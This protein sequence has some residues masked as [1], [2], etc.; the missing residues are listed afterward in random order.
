MTKSHALI[1]APL[2]LAFRRSFEEAVGDRPEYLTVA[3]LRRLRPGAAVRQLLR[4]R[5]GTCYLPIEDETSSAI[6]PVLQAVALIGAPRSIEVVDPNLVRRPV[7]RMRAARGVL[8]LSAASLAGQL[9]LRRQTRELIRLAAMPRHEVS[10]GSTQRV[11]YFNGNLWFGLKAGG[12]V[13]HVAGVVNGFVGGGLDVDLATA[14]TPP[15]VRPEVNV[16][17]LEPPRAFG[18]PVEANIYRFQPTAV[19]AVLRRKER[20][21]FVYQRMSVGSFAG[22][23]ISRRLGIPLV[24]EYNGSEVWVAR[25]WGR[26]LRTE[27]TATLA[28]AVSLRHADVVVTVSDVLRNEVIARGVERDRVLSYPNCVD[29]D[30]FM[31]ELLPPEERAR[32]RTSWGV[33]D[34]S[35][36]V[37]FIGTF[38]QWHGAEVLAE[39]ARRLLDEQ[40]AWVEAKDVRFLFVG[41]GLGLPNVQQILAGHER[42][43]FTGLVPQDDAPRLLLAS[44]VLVS[45]HVR[46]ADGTPF[47][48]SPTK[49]FEYMA[50][51]RGIIASRLDQIAE[52]LAPSIDASALPEPGPS[53]D[54][55]SCSVLTEPGDVEQLAHAI[56]FLVDRP[57]WR[58]HLGDNARRRVID[59]YTWSHHVEAIL[60]AVETHLGPL[61]ATASGAR[62]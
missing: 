39:A 53:A 3:E 22:V 27:A 33:G 38:G 14:G 11:L 45:P 28:E 21:A 17:R 1:A 55:E 25:N 5:G 16:I 46:N 50:A 9:E 56:R 10:I 52:V 37:S 59:R 26:P 18:I 15:L 29:P 60:D 40:A 23:E 51:A 20:Y 48:G 62:L 41:D 19:D 36:V 8:G 30:R 43:V 54:D 32:L 4:N 2:S 12:S 13:G 61:P 44:D 35:V 31:P 6:L 24:L 7:S 34:E 58:A 49:L 42:C 57:D 47:F